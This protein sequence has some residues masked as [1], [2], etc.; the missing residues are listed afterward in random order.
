MRSFWTYTTMNRVLSL[1][2]TQLVFYTQFLMLNLKKTISEEMGK[3]QTVKG[4][5]TVLHKIGP[6][7]NFNQFDLKLS[8]KK[9]LGVSSHS[10]NFQLN[11]YSFSLFPY[12]MNLAL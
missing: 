9:D 6:S 1:K 12:P 2:L 5:G 10:C 8:A 11:R 7:R 4:R 3:K